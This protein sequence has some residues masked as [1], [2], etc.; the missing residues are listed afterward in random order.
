VSVSGRRV[1]VTVAL[2]ALIVLVPV[3]VY[4]WGR[5]SPAFEVRRVAVRDRMAVHRREVRRVLRT[6]FLG[7]NLFSVGAD[8][9]ERALADLPYVRTVAVDRAFPHTLKVRLTEYVPRAL[10]LSGG[11]WYVVSGEGKVLEELGVKPS[12]SGATAT[13]SPATD[14]VSATSTSDASDGPGTSASPS[15]GAGVTAVSGTGQSSV[16]SPSPSGSAR[17]RPSAS[18]SPAAAAAGPPPR[19]PVTLQMTRRVARLPSLAASEPVA[20]GA[21]VADP[22]V[23]AALAA[24]SALP[25]SQ[26]RRVTGATATDTSIRLYCAGGP[27]VELGD[28]SELASK[29]LALRAVLARYRTRQVRC[30]FVD[31]SVPNRPLA[32]PLLPAPSVQSSP[33]SG[34]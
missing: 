11:R 4:V 9:V 12:S 31:V 16:T 29:V 6:E 20:I 5:S 26:A 27:T 19:P 1:V 3:A 17:P 10:L 2:A 25:H 33:T 23:R 7:K 8:D 24:L 34:Q 13:A 22:H 32:A 14:G 15:P 21:T 28:T 30:T 18:A